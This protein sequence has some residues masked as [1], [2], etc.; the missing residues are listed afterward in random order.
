MWRDFSCYSCW[1]YEMQKLILR[2]ICQNSRS[3]FSVWDNVGKHEGFK[4]LSQVEL[5]YHKTPQKLRNLLSTEGWKRNARR[6]VSGRHSKRQIHIREGWPPLLLAC[7]DRPPEGILEG[8]GRQWTWLVDQRK[9]NRILYTM[10]E[11]VC[12]TVHLTQRLYG[13]T[14]ITMDIFICWAF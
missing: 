6:H 13:Q 12:F 8:R 1:F 7:V 4:S 3:R 10:V 14:W 5:L 2:S 9:R 11:H